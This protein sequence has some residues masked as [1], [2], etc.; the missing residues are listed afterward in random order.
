MW[1]W[2]IFADG[3]SSS[4]TV[5]AWTRVGL[6]KT[7]WGPPSC[8]HLL[9]GGPW[10]S[11][12]VQ[13][14]EIYKYEDLTHTGRSQGDKCH[15]ANGDWSNKSECLSLLRHVVKKTHLGWYNGY[16][17]HCYPTASAWR[18][19]LMSPS[20]KKYYILVPVVSSPVEN[21]SCPQSPHCC[22]GCLISYQ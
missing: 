5:Q 3:A 19:F 17:S 12:H 6:P 22:A 11:K 2:A 8:W 13:Q 9:G 10:R 7:N 18:H 20:Y 15:S 14:A 21:P 16:L 4:E 1:L